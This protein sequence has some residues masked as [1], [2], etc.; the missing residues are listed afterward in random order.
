MNILVTGVPDQ[1]APGKVEMGDPARDDTHINN[2][3]II[4][5]YNLKIGGS[6]HDGSNLEQNILNDVDNAI[7]VRLSLTVLNV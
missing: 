3:T 6:L 5:N 7:F 1:Q 4:F 2:T